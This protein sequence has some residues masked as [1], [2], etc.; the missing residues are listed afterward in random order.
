MTTHSATAIAHP[1]IAFIK[2]WGNLDHDARLPA[3]GS[4]SM[5]LAGLETRTTVTFDP[6]LPADQLSVNGERLSGPKLARVSRLLDNV[7]RMADLE[8]FADVHSENNFPAGAGIASSSSAFAALGLAAS[9]AAGL[10]LDEQELS[11]LARTG[12]GS[13]ARSIPP[14]FVELLAGESHAESYAHSIAPPEHWDLSDC[15]AVVSAEHK[16]V[17]STQGHQ[18]A[19]TSPLQPARV[20]D[21]PRR[22]ELCRQAVLKRDFQTFAEVVEHDCQLMHA[23]MMTSQ[24]PL[25]YWQPATLAIIQAVRAWREDSLPVCYTIDAGPNVH[26]LCPRQHRQTVEGKLREIPG[27]AQV[28]VAGVGGGARL[29]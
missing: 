13:A 7:R 28:L 26:V 19:E 15:I 12:S 11:R 29:A 14:G 21:A 5:N 8:T 1:N 24:P 27:V 3:N 16:A 25:I 20:A 10:Q 4:L 6:G 9:A 18:L 22:L 17:G 2:Y 23:I